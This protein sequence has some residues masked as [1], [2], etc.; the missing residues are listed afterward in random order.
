MRSR[1]FATAAVAAIAA[2]TLTQSMGQPAIAQPTIAA[3]SR[4]FDVGNLHVERFGQ[5]SPA[6]ILIP[7]LSMGAWTWTGQIATFAGDHAVYAV[8]IDGFDGTPVSPPPIIAKADT[9]IL[10]LV[11]Q[12]NLV[13]PVLVGHSLGGH[14]ALRLVEEHSDLFACAVLLDTMPYFPPPAAGQS[15][16]QRE[17]G[18]EQLA[19]GIQTAPDWLYEEQ[20][21]ATVSGMVTDA[22]E[23]DAVVQHSLTSDRT[24]LAQ[25]TTEMSTEDL[26]PKLADISVPVLVVAPVS[27]QA[28]Y[29]NAALRALT[30]D[31]L[32]ATVRDWYAGQYAGAKTVTVQTIANSKHFIMLDQPDALNAEIRTFL[33]ALSPVVKP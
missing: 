6:L 5:G 2:V 15:A 19:E 9:A 21:R 12:E 16:Q 4:S 18:I 27:S 28:P 30:P 29:M 8:T 11:K 1:T 7:G 14:L 24:T 23:V 20:T 13:K 31:Q 25:A 33:N 22:H 32:T 26:R 17:Q 3:P 10:Q